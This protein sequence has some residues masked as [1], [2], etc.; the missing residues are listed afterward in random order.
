MYRQSFPHAPASPLQKIVSAVL[1]VALLAMGLMFSVVL[2]AVLAVAGLAVFGYLWWQTRAIRRILR[3]GQVPTAT[4]D[5]VFDG[6]ATVV[7]TQEQVS[8]VDVRISDKTR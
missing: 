7:E 2:L 4:D 5:R 8:R 6:E 3:E 1:G